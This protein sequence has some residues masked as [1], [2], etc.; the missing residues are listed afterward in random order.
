MDQ[1]AGRLAEL[2]KH[3]DNLSYLN[4]RRNGITAEGARRLAEADLENSSRSV[5]AVKSALSVG[6][7]KK[8]GV[9]LDTE[10]KAVPDA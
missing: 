2:L 10:T 3:N 5:S 6:D 9:K 4:I 8:E 1:G 7:R